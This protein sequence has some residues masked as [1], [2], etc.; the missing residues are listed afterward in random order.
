[1]TNPRHDKKLM[2]AVEAATEL[3]V[4]R[5]R[6]HQLVEERKLTGLRDRTF[7]FVSRAEVAA[8]RGAKG[9]RRPPAGWLTKQDVAERFGVTLRTVHGWYQRG[10]LPGLMSDNRV[11]MFRPSDVAT[12]QRPRPGRPAQ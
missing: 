8:M 6:I 9:K 10:L 2:P 1:M 11:L 4:S 12:F 3:G 7:L 5:Q